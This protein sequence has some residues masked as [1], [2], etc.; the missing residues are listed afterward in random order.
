MQNTFLELK[1]QYWFS[2]KKEPTSLQN[3]KSQK[4]LQ[5]LTWMHHH[6]IHIMKLYQHDSPPKE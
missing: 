5:N 2:Y 6:W 1:A 3:F 4:G